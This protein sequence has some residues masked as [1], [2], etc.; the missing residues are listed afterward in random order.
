MCDSHTR[1]HIKFHGVNKKLRVGVVSGERVDKERPYLLFLANLFKM[2]L[3]T[4]F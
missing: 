2:G 3:T 4:A 1:V